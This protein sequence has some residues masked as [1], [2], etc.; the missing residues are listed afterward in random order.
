LLEL[1]GE[2]SRDTA[3]GRNIAT[4][5]TVQEAGS[6]LTG[7]VS[8]NKDGR[9]QEADDDDCLAEWHI[10]MNKRHT[11]G[12]HQCKNFTYRTGVGY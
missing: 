9:S 5:A 12:I 2:E 3:E 7:V 4:E 1:Q 11:V 6:K 10:G 8:R